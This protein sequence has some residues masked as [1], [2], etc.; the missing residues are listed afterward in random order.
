MYPPASE[1]S[2]RN[3]TFPVPGGALAASYVVHFNNLGIE[4]IHGSINPADKPATP[5]PMITIF[6]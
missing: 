4:A 2:S 6:F 5:L 3:D 1:G